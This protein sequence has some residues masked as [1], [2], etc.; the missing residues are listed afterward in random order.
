MS[1]NPIPPKNK[2]GKLLLFPLPKPDPDPDNPTPAASALTPKILPFR[3][4]AGRRKLP[5]PKAA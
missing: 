1:A 5:L 3:A 2:K 4:P